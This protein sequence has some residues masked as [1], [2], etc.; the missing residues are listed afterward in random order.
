MRKFCAYRRL[1]RPYT[2]ISKYREKSFIRATPHIN[3]VKFDMGNPKR[4]YGY[5]LD[6]VSKSDLQIR[7]NAL[8]SARMTCNRLLE[9]QLGKNGY[10]LKVK[11]YP[12]HILRENPLAA[13]AGAD[14]MSTGMKMSFGKAISSAARIKKGQSIFS[15]KV[16]KQNLPLAKKALK[17]ATYKIP[18]K[19]HIDIKELKQAN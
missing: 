4:E 9:L 7:H 19:C 13:G 17:R 2:R 16:N 12:F 18:C 14:R 5:Q 1:E 10:F 6:L 15:L 8:E 3:L 11:P